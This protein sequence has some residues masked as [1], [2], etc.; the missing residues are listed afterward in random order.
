MT[1]TRAEAEK[2]FQRRITLEFDTHS[3]ALV[4]VLRK[5]I[6]HD[7]PC[8]VESLDF[9]VFPM[10]FY[11]GFPMRVFFTDKNNTEFFIM[12]NGE[13]NYPSPVDPSL[14]DIPQLC[15]ES[16]EKEIFGE[17]PETDTWTLA[18]DTLIAWFFGRWFDAGGAEFT[19]SATIALHDDRAYYELPCKV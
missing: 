5:L 9:V 2:E 12:R 8:E 7:Y 10:N 17:D 19:R 4:N 13:A 16:I 3:V 11:S 15:S 1:N 6:A 14:L 18:G